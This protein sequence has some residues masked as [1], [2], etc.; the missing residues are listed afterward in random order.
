M[1]PCFGR[2]QKMELVA[3]GADVTADGATPTCDNSEDV[4]V[5][6]LERELMHVTI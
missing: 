1:R 6:M 3:G 4:H 2:G 5:F